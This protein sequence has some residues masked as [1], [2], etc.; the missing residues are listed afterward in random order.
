[1]LSPQQ[2]PL[3]TLALLAA[4][5][6]APS[7]AQTPGTSSS[8][9]DQLPSAPSATLIAQQ[10]ESLSKNPG[11]GFTLKL[12]TT[13]GPGA[14]ANINI[15]QPTDA[16]L[17][18]SIDQAMALGMERNV[19]LL[20]DR[21]NQK[22][23]KGDT[24]GIK[25][26][27]LPDLSISAQSNAQQ[28]NLAAMG[29]KPAE[30]LKF[31]LNPADFPLIVKVQTTSAQI[32]AS[33]QLFNMTDLEL[34]RGTKFEI[35]VIDLNELS[36]EG[37]VVLSTG[38][39]YLKILADQANLDNAQAQQRSSQTVFSQADQKFK[40]GVGVRL[41]SLRAQVDYQQRQQD[42][43]AAQAALDKDTIQLNRI[44]GLPA[45]QKLE[46]TD[47]APFAEFD[48]M[49]LE[50]A[51]IT[52]YEHRKDYLSLQAQIDVAQRELRA[53]K[54]QRLPTLAFNGFYGVLGQTT[55]LYHGDFT[56]EG[57]LKFPIF[58]EAGQRGE[59]DSASAQ[60]MA[61][62]QRQADAR[63]AIDAQIRSSMLDVQSAAQL[64]KVAQSNVDLAQ[65]ELSDE[66]DRFSA[67]VDDN[68]PLVDAETT[69]TGA[70]ANL[71]NALYQYNVA[72]LNLARNT[73]V[74]E[75]RYRAYLGK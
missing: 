66:R 34:Y 74:V 51:R 46:L 41:D 69:L 26:A 11:N 10:A 70:Q 75:N 6:A 9:A 62:R 13:P 71:V 60:L 67:G 42:T 63:I 68:L 33:Q 47:T 29:F 48:V 23:V 24:L 50:A 20:Y 55:G 22:Q 12:I 36:S 27:L 53:V 32:N 7:L 38:T 16:P 43:I 2:H 4:L 30:L 56:A 8:T 17:P 49:P 35:R 28:L 25:N 61:L 19:R 5:V 45:G 65:Q 57:T 64:V 37:E 40:A 59:E 72:K 21:A 15:E 58:R 14:L 44:I 31:G 3:K 18:L 52:A 39:A 73:G 1:M 54:Y